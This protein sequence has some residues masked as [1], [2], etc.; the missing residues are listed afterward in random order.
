MLGSNK[1][2]TVYAKRG[3]M[4]KSGGL[5]D[6]NGIWHMAF[7]LRGHRVA[8]STHT[9]NK[10]DAEMILARR[11]AALIQD[12]VLDNKKVSTFHA[13]ID[14]YTSTRTTDASK[15]NAKYNLSS[16]KSIADGPLKKIDINDV[17]AVLQ[18]ARD[19]GYKPS[20]VAIRIRYWNAFINW[21][22]EQK[23]HHPG[24]LKNAKLPQGR[25]RYLTPEEQEKLLHALHPDRMYRGKSAEKDAYRRDNHHFVIFLLDTGVRFMEAGTMEW[26]QVDLVRGEISINRLK[27]GEHTTIGLTDRLRAV[28]VERRSLHPTHIFPNK[29]GRN[30][31]VVW[32]RNA[33]KAAG[34][35]TAQGSIT[36]HTMR[37]T[38]A[39][40]L[41]QTGVSLNGV[42]H[43]LGHK[44][45][46]QTL[47]YAHIAKQDV[48]NDVVRILNT[49]NKPANVQISQVIPLRVP[50]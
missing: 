13:A 44:D 27:G 19:D 43:M 6:R 50:A 39:A 21:C 9:S 16:F 3:K 4:S 41:I 23:F 5:I 11:K 10:R 42:Q 45:I 8:E 17:K 12:V 15:H 38:F 20:T 46:A 32:M 48:A 1:L 18:K 31:S 49:L 40:K 29:N 47:R 36:P 22:A 7:T 25:T 28:L 24:K 35:S 14:K 33:V 37:H 34:I 26:N 30:H 2:R